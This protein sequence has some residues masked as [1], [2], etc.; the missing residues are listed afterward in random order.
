M[1]TPELVANWVGGYGCPS[2]A[3]TLGRGSAVK[4]VSKNTT[5]YDFDIDVTSILCTQ[6]IEVVETNVT[7]T[8][9]SLGVIP[10]DTPPAPDE[11]TAKY[12][13]NKLSH[14]T[15]PIFEFPLNNLLLTLAYGVGNTTVSAPDGSSGDKNQLDPFTEFL[16]TSNASSPM[17]SLIGQGN[18]QNLIDATNRLYKT[19]MPQ[20]IDR[21]MRTKNLE[22]EIATPDA[23]AAKVEPLNFT[24]QPEFPR[25]RLKQ[26]AA[27]K[28]AIQVILGVM[29]LCAVGGRVLLKGM[30]RL[31]P[32]NPCSIA[33]RAALFA[34]GEVSTRR[35]VPYGAE[36]RSEAELMK[37]GVWEGWLF[38]LGW[39]ESWG[40]YKYG[41]D[42]GWIDRGRV[43]H[44]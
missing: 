42:I 20:A 44:E 31:V 24:A 29:V 1:Y 40:V 9:P 18:T 13:V 38:S 25:L 43:R 37:M 21:N 8:L 27:P 2:F 28:I 10:Q 30:D 6:R 41:V 35:L 19:Y 12:L 14:Y 34:D 17:D 26:E 33:G 7:L 3:V 4:K 32:H 11:S 16:A 15:G 23:V 39:W 22:A 36:W 5:T